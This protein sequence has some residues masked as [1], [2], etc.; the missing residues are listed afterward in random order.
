[1]ARLFVELLTVRPL[2]VFTKH[3]CTGH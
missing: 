1:L 3:Q 2:G